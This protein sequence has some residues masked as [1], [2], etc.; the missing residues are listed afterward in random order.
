MAGHGSADS[1]LLFLLPRPRRLQRLE[2]TWSL[3]PTLRLACSEQ[4]NATG[5]LG[6]L[7]H[8]LRARGH[9][10]ERTT[11]SDP[12]AH[13]RMRV[14]PLGFGAAL[15]ESLA[16]QAYAAIV[17]N[18]S[19]TLSAISAI[20]L[21]YA[22]STLTQLIELSS[23]G[24]G[25]LELPCV[26]IEDSP[27]FPVRGVMLDISRDKVPTLATLQA[28]V[29]R[30]AHWK[31]NQLQLYMEHTF[32]YAGHEDV[33]RNA[34]PLTP[35]EVRSF[36]TYCA[37]RQVELVPNQNSFGHMHRWLVHEPYRKLAECPDGFEHPWSG[38]G[39]PY[40]LSATDPATLGFLE[41]LYDE[42]LPNFR[43]RLF[44]VG[45]DEPL[46]LGRGRSKSAC[47]ARGAG[48]VYVDFL[49]AVHAR[50]KSRGRTMAFWADTIT[51][52]PELMTE[53]PKDAIAL[54]WGYE[55]SHPFA[56]HLA[57]LRG[58]G[59]TC[60]V[61]PGTS[62]WNSFAGRTHN[63]VENIAKAAREGKA[64]GATGLLIA[65]WGDHG[66]LQPLSVSYVGFVLGAAF[67]WNVADA[68]QPFE[69]DLPRLLDVH[70]FSD[71]ASVLGRV[72]YDLGDA[73]RH[74]GSL[75]PNASL[76]FFSVLKA[77]R[78]FSPPGATR[79]TLEQT[80]A[81]VQR[82][83]AALS[84]ARPL[85]N[86]GVLTVEELRYARDLL[87]FACR[88]GMA[89]STLT[90]PNALALLPRAERAELS[91]TLGG[92]I[93]RHGSL[94]AARNRPGGQRDSARHLTR[95]LEALT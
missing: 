50:V 24:R 44:N 55:A 64:A 40:G 68:Q 80:L 53:V 88:L 52:S 17:M 93:A 29:D 35:E 15:A 83:G 1:T 8:V 42:L 5:A 27:D 14:E 57:A 37:A 12:A 94:W 70:A 10:L 9:G 31:V 36:D 77:E 90:D 43:S 19:A 91:L 6:R 7:E 30:L 89:R 59:L 56:E 62:S 45:L 39:E 34:S 82:A 81:Y 69:L 4:V 22:L 33:W 78:L 85:T 46:D 16:N 47:E 95:V 2:G 66:H 48:R 71:S 87:S 21:A 51:S 72:A 58:A 13:V 73:Y 63:A 74:A 61:C 41:S 18:G 11:A 54:E 60:Y 65:D 25:A 20:G 32:A 28:L 76:L 75:R 3:P 84:S 86:E 79:E 26:S 38:K 49:K 23:G 92:I 67:G